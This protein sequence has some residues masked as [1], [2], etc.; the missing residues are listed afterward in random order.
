[1]PASHDPGGRSRFPLLPG[2]V[3]DARFADEQNEHRL[4]LSRRMAETPETEPFL[5]WVCMNPSTAGADLDDP[6]VRKTWE[7]TRRRGLRRMVLT[8]A[9][10]YCLTDPSGLAAIS[11]PLAHPG[12][13]ELIVA[14]AKAAKEV[15]VA[16]GNP[17]DPI[18]WHAKATLDALKSSGVPLLCL[19]RTASGWPKHPSR[20]AYAT[21]LETY[22]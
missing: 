20:L 7:I 15:V 1:M 8:N 11:A 17:P 14:C 18:G 21:K 13:V 4:W 3:G 10:T 19:G 6:L 12:N 9:A 5:L 2:V 22:P 16:C